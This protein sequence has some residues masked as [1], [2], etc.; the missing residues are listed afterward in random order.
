MTRDAGSFDAGPALSAQITM[1]PEQHHK[2]ILRERATRLETEFRTQNLVDLWPRVADLRSLHKCLFDGLCPTLPQ[3]VGTYRG[4]PGTPLEFAKR[5]VRTRGQA[6]G[7][8]KVD[9]CLDPAKV[10]HGMDAFTLDLRLFWFSDTR[11]ISDLGR[12]THAFFSIH[13]FL[14]G[15]GH[16][17]RL[18]IIALARRSARPLNESWQV[19][20]RPFG[21]SF[22][23]ALQHYQSDP[24][25]L[26]AELASFQLD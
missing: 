23:L 13:P 24:T 25:L 19:A 10:A 17:W 9:R 22:S 3:A 5:A 7:L 15:N 16:L 1:A 14:D 21:P 2:A 26:N 6:P 8:R 12:L 20:Q 11:E 4:T 18:V